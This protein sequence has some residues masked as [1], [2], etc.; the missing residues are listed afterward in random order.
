MNN[1][2]CNIARDLMPLCIDQ[3]ASEESCT[4][5][6]AH[7]AVCS[8]CSQVYA[9][10]QVKTPEKKD[11]AEDVSFAAAM[12]Q[13][14]RT[15]GWRRIKV[16]ILCAV[17]IPAMLVVGY[18]SYIHFF[19]DINRPMQLDWYNLN[20]SR[21]K[22]GIVLI[23]MVNTEGWVNYSTGVGR[24]PKNPD[25]VYISVHCPIIPQKSL[26]DMDKT[27]YACYAELRWEDGKCQLPD[28]DNK[29]VMHPVKEIRKGTDSNYEVLYK[30][31]EDVPLCPPALEEYLAMK[32]SDEMP[33]DIYFSANLVP[34]WR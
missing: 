30:E 29:N 31:G 11:V 27:E 12:R 33:D 21:T 32:Y 2:E 22:N 6:E 4:L 17:I 23:S 13:L 26:R 15:V 8:D 9:D 20:L 1:T 10:M 16:I 3:V 28:V 19:L 7:V 18:L 14:R 24:G 5:V 34:E 25:I